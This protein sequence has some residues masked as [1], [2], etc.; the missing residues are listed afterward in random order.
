MIYEHWDVVDLDPVTWRNL[1]PYFDPRNFTTRGD[2]SERTL[3]ILHDGGQVL[4]VW[5]SGKGTRH[6]LDLGIIADPLTKAKELYESNQGWD[7]VQIFDKRSVLSFSH[8]AQESV[9]PEWDLDEYIAWVWELADADP[10]GLCYY[11][12]RPRDWNGWCYSKVKHFVEEVIP[13]HSTLVLGVIE[14]GA[15]WA[16]L[17]LGVRDRKIK[18]VTTFD[19]LIPLGLSPVTGLE[20]TDEVVALVGRKF[21]PP[22]AALFCTR[23]VFEEW[24]RAEDKVGALKRALAEGE[25]VVN[26]GA[27]YLR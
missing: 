10:E 20:H 14:D 11:P 16:G 6:D 12:P 17:I 1:G 22:A 15:L 9:H 7:R 19:A 2:P 18:L 27:E 25:A 8:Q 23:Q 13:D 21:D 26:P 4:K 5:D 24:M 3:S